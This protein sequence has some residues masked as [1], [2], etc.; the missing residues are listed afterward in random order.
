MGGVN[1]DQSCR[2]EIRCFAFGTT[3][4]LKSWGVCKFTILY[5]N[6]IKNYPKVF[7]KIQIYFL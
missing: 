3:A 1:N 2:H 6:N 7:N 5:V 4:F